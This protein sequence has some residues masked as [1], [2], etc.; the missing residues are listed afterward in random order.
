MYMNLDYNSSS[1]IRS[2]SFGPINNNIIRTTKEDKMFNIN[3][4]KPTVMPSNKI[5]KEYIYIGVASVI[6]I[7]L[8]NNK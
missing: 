4:F 6:I 8:I 7:I 3:E 2:K 5:K 1:L